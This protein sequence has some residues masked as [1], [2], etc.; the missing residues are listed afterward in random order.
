MPAAAVNGSAPRSRVPGR[1]RAG[2]LPDAAPATRRRVVIADD[3]PAIRLLFRRLLET[4]PSFEVVGEAA[5]GGEAV[6]LAESEHPDLVLL[7]LAM[8]VIDGLEAIPALRRCSPTTRIV[9]LSGFDANRMENEA[10]ACGADAYIEK[11]LLPDALLARILEACD[12]PVHTGDGVPRP[13]LWAGAKECDRLTAA[14]EHAPNAMAFGGLNGRFHAVNEAFCS[15]LGYSESE[16]LKRTF[17]EV[18]DRG[19]SLSQADRH[20]Q[21]FARQIPSYDAEH[22]FVHAEGWTVWTYLSRTL[23]PGREGETPEVLTQ[24][25]DRTELNRLEVRQM[26]S[27]SARARYEREAARASADLAQLARILHGADEIDSIVDGLLAYALVAAAAPADEIVD[28]E[29]VMLVVRRDLAPAITSSGAAVTWDALPAVTGDAPQLAQ[30]LESLLSNALK[31]VA[32]GVAPAVHI[33][34]SRVHDG[35]QL[36]MTDN[37]VGIDADD[38]TRVFSIFERVNRPALCPGRGVGLAICQR[39][40]ERRGGEITI[41]PNAGAPGSCVSFTIPD[42]PAF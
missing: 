10:L 21:L 37:G 27:E 42:E 9:V 17:A 13:H 7:D 14:F 33:R 1:R 3:A 40:V 2:V 32:P 20:E 6:R 11:R 30:L 16:L 39:I 19:D 28:L 12:G 29:D 38:A 31:F 23:M 15:L 41:E 8:P 25:V 24:V 34:A 26:R 35:W 4:S 22:R 36:A 5:D 18:S